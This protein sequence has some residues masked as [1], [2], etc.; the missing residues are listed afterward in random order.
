MADYIDLDYSMDKDQF[1]NIEYKYDADAVKQSIID[2]LLTKIGEREFMPTYG[3]KLYWILFEKMTPLT[4][5][6]IQ[7]EIFIALKN[8]EP[9]ISVQEVNITRYE[10]ENY[11]DILISFNL[12]R[13][14]QAETL[15]LQLKR[16]G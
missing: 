4:E 5:I 14:N 3:S 11:Y 15:N 16:I 12:I 8:W 10:D 2:I 6:R 13:L 1:G 9:R 7:D